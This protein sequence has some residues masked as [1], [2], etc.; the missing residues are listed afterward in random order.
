MKDKEDSQLSVFRRSIRSN[1]NRFSTIHKYDDIKYTDQLSSD[2]S[3]MFAF[4]VGMIGCFGIMTGF[5]M[6]IN[7]S[8]MGLF[9]I[10]AGLW[11]TIPSK[12]V[13]KNKFK[14]N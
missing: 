12:K 8:F 11:L 10:I 13:M 14:S 1:M 6:L 5:M 2:L 9:M 3:L 4:S 7:F